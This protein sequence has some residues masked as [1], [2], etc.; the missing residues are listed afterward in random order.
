MI[1]KTVLMVIITFLVNTVSY[2]AA[3]QITI[4]VNNNITTNVVTVT[5]RISGNLSKYVIL[6]VLKPG[7]EN[8]TVEN[9]NEALFY[10]EDT[11]T[12]DSGNYSFQFSLRDG[13]SGNYTFKTATADKGVYTSTTHYCVNVVLV[14]NTINEINYANSWEEIADIFETGN[15]CKILSIDTSLFSQVHN[16][17]TLYRKIYRE[18]QITPFQYSELERLNSLF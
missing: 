3:A 14:E 11:Y 9:I 12:D 17:E 1:K 8:A 5:G 10:T 2:A 7:F 13:E 16:R 15:A 6:Q 18:K 4:E